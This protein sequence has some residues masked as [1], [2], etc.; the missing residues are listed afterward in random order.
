MICLS[1][2]KTCAIIIGLLKASYLLTYAEFL[3]S[4]NLITEQQRGFIQKK[5]HAP[6]Y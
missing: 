2:Y 4:E 3:L 6:T 5:Q 1:C